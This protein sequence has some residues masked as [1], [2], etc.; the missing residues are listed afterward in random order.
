MLRRV[1]YV[2]GKQEGATRDVEA[3]PCLRACT[4]W[5]PTAHVKLTFTSICTGVQRHYMYITRSSRHPMQSSP[6]FAGSAGARIRLAHDSHP[7]R[8]CTVPYTYNITS[9]PRVSHPGKRMMEC[10]GRRRLKR[11][12]EAGRL[13]PPSVH[14]EWSRVDRANRFPSAT[15]PRAASIH[16]GGECSRV[17]AMTSIA[18]QVRSELAR[19][20]NHTVQMLSYRRLAET[21]ATR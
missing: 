11:E 4:S 14:L 15:I 18:R 8:N 10:V 20:H 21:Q 17:R 12:A 5:R 13:G 1:R 6:H 7:W 19:L 3:Q 9:C 2:G 16:V